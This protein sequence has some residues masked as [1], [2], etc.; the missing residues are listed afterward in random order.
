MAEKWKWS[1]SRVRAAAELAVEL[2][3]SIELK[4]DGSMLISPAPPQ[5]V[6]KESALEKWK[7]EQA[8]RS[9]EPP[10]LSPPL[11]QRE[12]SALRHIIGAKG[13]QNA[14]KI[15]GCGPSTLNSLVERGLIEL[16]EAVEGERVAR[17][18]D[19]GQRAWEASRW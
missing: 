17:V 4:P 3:V 15:A 2:S 13:K 10:F 5:T 9:P 16:V 7:A 18:T 1:G 12:L 19:L 14:T 6:K 11:G 8:A